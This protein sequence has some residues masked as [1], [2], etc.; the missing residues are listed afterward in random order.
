MISLT[1]DIDLSSERVVIEKGG[2]S[3]KIYMADS[4]DHFY[5]DASVS[6]KCEIGDFDSTFEKLLN[7]LDKAEVGESDF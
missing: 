2:I 1:K 7:K 3:Y 4:Y 6:A 5:I